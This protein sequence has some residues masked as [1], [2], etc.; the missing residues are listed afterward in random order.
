MVRNRIG[1]QRIQIRAFAQ[2]NVAVA[3]FIYIY[4]TFFCI[5]VTGLF[6]WF[7]CIHCSN[8]CTGN[9]QNVSGDN[10]VVVGWPGH[11]L[12]APGAHLS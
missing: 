8:H 1:N 9:G 4:N 2:R 3:L 12:H 11:K 6:G 10:E 5:S 7:H